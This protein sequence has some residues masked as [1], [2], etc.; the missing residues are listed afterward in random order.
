MYFPVARRWW[1][2]QQSSQLLSVG[3]DY[4]WTQSLILSKTQLMRRE[5]K[6]ALS[7]SVFVVI[8]DT[9]T[10]LSSL[11]IP[12]PSAQV[13]WKKEQIS[14][15]TGRQL[16]VLKV[17]NLSISAPIVG[18]NWDSIHLYSE[19]PRRLILTKHLFFPL[20]HNIFFIDTDSFSFP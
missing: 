5:M 3:R 8:C 6:S 12:P 15:F 1:L 10:P 17:M 2:P 20:F 11:F 14:E 9:F 19:M 13:L 7:H 16:R 4:V 18:S